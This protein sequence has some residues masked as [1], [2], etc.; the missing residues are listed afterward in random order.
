MVGCCAVRTATRM[1]A[2]MADEGAVGR[3]GSGSGVKGGTRGVDQQAPGPATAMAMRRAAATHFIQPP[4]EALPAVVG[5]IGHPNVGKSSVINPLLG[6]KRVSVSRA[7]GHTKH[8][9][10]LQ[11][12]GQAGRGATMVH[13]L[14]LVCPCRGAGGSWRYP[15]RDGAGGGVQGG[16]PSAAAGWGGSGSDA[17]P[18]DTNS[19]PAHQLRTSAH[20]HMRRCGAAPLPVPLMSSGGLKLQGPALQVVMQDAPGWCRWRRYGS[21][22]QW[23]ASCARRCRLRRCWASHRSRTLAVAVGAGTVQIY[24]SRAKAAT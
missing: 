11:V 18:A 10:S 19:E 14:G 3:A 23:C 15:A 9:Q 21:R 4:H 22:T 1:M 6:G 2:G 13:C 20:A 7:P 5:M 24:S 17:A 8:C 12:A 16:A